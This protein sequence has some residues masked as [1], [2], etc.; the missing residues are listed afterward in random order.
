MQTPEEPTDDT[1][2]APQ[3]FDFRIFRYSPLGTLT[4]ICACLA[5]AALRASAINGSR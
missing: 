3:I 1:L 5:L 4:V 2:L